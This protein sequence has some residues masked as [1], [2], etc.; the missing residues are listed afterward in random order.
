[1]A[2]ENPQQAHFIHVV[3]R[4]HFVAPIEDPVPTLNETFQRGMIGKVPVLKG[5]FRLVE[6]QGIMKICIIQ[7][8]QDNCS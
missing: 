8:E 4:L 6:S 1:M 2:P 5:S 3:A 7:N